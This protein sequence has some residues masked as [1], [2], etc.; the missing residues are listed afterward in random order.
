MLWLIILS[1]V[2]LPNCCG[3]IRAKAR[4]IDVAC[5]TVNVSARSRTMIASMGVGWAF[6]PNKPQV[7]AKTDKLS[8][9]KTRSLSKS[10]GTEAKRGNEADLWPSTARAQTEIERLCSSQSTSCDARSANAQMNPSEDGS[11]PWWVRAHNRFAQFWALFS[12]G[13]GWGKREKHWWLM[14][15]GHLCWTSKNMR[16]SVQGEKNERTIQKC[17]CRFMVDYLQPLQTR[18][19]FI[20][21]K[22]VTLTTS[23]SPATIK[24]CIICQVAENDWSGRSRNELQTIWTR[25]PEPIWRNVAKAQRAFAMSWQRGGREICCA[26]TTP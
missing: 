8:D 10:E 14:L 4:R 17:Q 23:G 15:H 26:R 16:K 25:R 9:E 22:Y 13:T 19:P 21:Y 11:F 2:D 6:T 7:H 18:S 24:H 20:R 5:S 12:A 3:H 1:H